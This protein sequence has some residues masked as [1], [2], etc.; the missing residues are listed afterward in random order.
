[1]NGH[2]LAFMRAACP[3]DLVLFFMFLCTATS[4]LYESPGDLWW[5]RCFHNCVK[6]QLHHSL[7]SRLELPHDNHDDKS[8]ILHNAVVVVNFSGSMLIHDPFH[9]FVLTSMLNTQPIGRR[10]IIPCWLTV[11][12][13]IWSWLRSTTAVSNTFAPSLPLGPGQQEHGVNPIISRIWWKGSSLWCWSVSLDCYAL[14]FVFARWCP[15]TRPCR[16]RI[17]S[18]AST[19]KHTSKALALRRP[20]WLYILSEDA[21][22]LFELCS[23]MKVFINICFKCYVSRTGPIELL[24][25]SQIQFPGYIHENI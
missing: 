11:T 2:S 21:I 9:I 4:H 3:F 16:V 12:T 22:L 14:P 24:I 5:L 17:E 10:N 20:L 15:P 23:Q 25:C 13:W 1:M 19:K 6:S 18:W 7:F 8:R